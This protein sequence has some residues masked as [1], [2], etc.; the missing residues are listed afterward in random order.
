MSARVLILLLLTL[1]ACLS[2]SAVCRYVYARIY[3]SPGLP[4]MS[5][6]EDVLC[7]IMSLTSARISAI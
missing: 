5:V 3:L 4:Y 2:L 7:D 6:G 1:I